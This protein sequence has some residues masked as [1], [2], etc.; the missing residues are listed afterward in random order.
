MGTAGKIQ[1][2]RRRHLRWLRG[3]LALASVA[4]GFATAGQA[5]RKD[6]GTLTIVVGA[7]PNLPVRLLAANKADI[8]AASLMFAPLA[9]LN[10]KLMTADESAF[11]PA[12]AR[13]WS[14]RDSLTLVFELDPRARW[15]DGT[16]I[17]SRDVVWTLNTAR[18]SAAFPVFALL[19]REIASVTAQGPE[20]V[21][22]TFKRAY[23]EQ[24][25]DVVYHVAPL[26]AHLLDTIPAKRLDASAFAANPVGSGPY[27]MGTREPGRQVD[28]VA[29]ADFFLGPPKITRIVFLLARN[30][31]AQLNLMLD[32]SADAFESAVLARQIA[33]V[34]G[35]P[36]LRIVTGPWLSVGYLLFNR[37]AYGDR[38]TA[39]PILADLGVRQ[40]I[41][42]ALDR[43]TLI[44]S[45]FG[46]YAAVAEG[47]M[48][49]ATWIRRVAPKQPGFD[50][51]RSRRLL[52]ERGWLDRDGDGI[53][54]K[55]GRP[56]SLRMMYPSSN[57]PRVALGEPIQEM[58]R[59]VGI[60]L[61]LDRLEP[62][63]WLQRRSRGEFD[64]DFSQVTLDP[65][66]TGIVQS[67]T[68]AGIGG[69]NA[70]SICDQSFDRAL[71]RAIAERDEPAPRWRD[72]IAALH[73]NAPA[74]FVF[75]PT[76]TVVLSTRYRQVDIRAEAPWSHVW[77]WSV[78]P[79]Q[80]LARDDR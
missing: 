17:T 60:K 10:K 9:W 65:S 76:Q 57:I 2:S 13:G 78:D 48:G 41:V 62:R 49:Q 73:A 36:N 55:D 34:V 29:R 64:I 58:L 26:P 42:H 7:E 28:F 5:Q 18:D 12:L 16:P 67:W 74:A 59:R 37:K 32:G 53:V 80:R 70:A 30:A 20:R 69:S 79:G 22:V 77:R 72:A 27:R 52:R 63:V 68:C 15:H 46:P 66:P 56:L 19:M 40:A 31:E 4:V 8:D 6:T 3:P 43:P 75:A 14:R 45:V 61:E 24:F 44:R 47:P 71:E 54:E 25:Y 21:V 23:A 50:P 39:H 1:R 11:E 33:P 51:D 35:R 38:Q